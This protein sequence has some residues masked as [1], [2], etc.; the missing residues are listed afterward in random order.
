MFSYRLQR[1]DFEKTVS[2]RDGIA[3]VTLWTRT[4]SAMAFAIGRS[5]LHRSAQRS[6]S[7]DRHRVVCLT[8]KPGCLAQ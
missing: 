5:L 4:P 2:E 7:G 3:F 6:R 1:R 8:E